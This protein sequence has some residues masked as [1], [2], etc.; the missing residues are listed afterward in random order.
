MSMAALV[1][2]IMVVGVQTWMALLLWVVG[3]L[4]YGVIHKPL[5]LLDMHG[6]G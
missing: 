4:G 6:C 3:F 5:S 2:E 1:V